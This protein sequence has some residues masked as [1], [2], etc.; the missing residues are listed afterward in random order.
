MHKQRACGVW[1]ALGNFGCQV[2]GHGAFGEQSQ[3]QRSFWGKVKVM[4][5]LGAKSRVKAEIAW[6]KILTPVAGGSTDCM[7][8]TPPCIISLIQLHMCGRKSNKWS[9]NMKILQ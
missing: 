7:A 5:V 8:V 9:G 1:V 6:S 4:E 2:K 3:G